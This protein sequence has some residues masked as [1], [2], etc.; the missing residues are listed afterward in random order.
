LHIHEAV[1]IA[2]GVRRWF[3]RKEN[4]VRGRDTEFDG[5]TFLVDAG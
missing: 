2:L 5:G 4:R 3:G 1:S